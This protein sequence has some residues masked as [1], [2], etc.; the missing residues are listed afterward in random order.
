MKCAIDKSNIG[1][2]EYQNTGVYESHIPED[3]SE[4]RSSWINMWTDAL[5]VN[6]DWPCSCVLLK[7]TLP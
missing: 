2:P 5:K 6:T 7:C 3:N 4:S 1:K